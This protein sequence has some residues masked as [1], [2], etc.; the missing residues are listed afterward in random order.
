MNRPGNSESTQP[1][2]AS[3]SVLAD[4]D[5]N[6]NNNPLDLPFVISISTPFS[7]NIANTFSGSQ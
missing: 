2:T 5:F 1:S 4:N 7:Y 6:N 3:T